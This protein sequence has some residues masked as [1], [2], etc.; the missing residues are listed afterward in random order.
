MTAA[1]S[2]ISLGSDHEAVFVRGLDGRL[3]WKEWR[4]SRGWS[5]WEPLGGSTTF[6]DSPAAVSRNP[7]VM[8]V[9][10]RANDNSLIQIYWERGRGW[11]SAWQTHTDGGRMTAAPSAVGLDGDSEMIIVRGL[12]SRLWHKWWQRGGVLTLPLHFK[13]VDL[14]TMFRFTTAQVIAATELVYA[15]ALVDAQVRSVEQLNNPGLLDIN[16]GACWSFGL[17]TTF[18][19]GQTALAGNR[20]NAGPDDIVVYFVRSATGF[21]GCAL[22]PDDKPSVLVTVLASAWVAA[23]EVGHKIGSGHDGSTDHIMFANDSFTNPPPNL[24]FLGPNRFIRRI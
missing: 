16:V 23:H 6:L 3:W 20:N 7:D 12:D 10:A 5:G 17:F 11:Q 9:Y 1:P 4:A 2:A 13:Y 14:P 8:N 19:F 22:S 24:D 18:N 15:G 21:A